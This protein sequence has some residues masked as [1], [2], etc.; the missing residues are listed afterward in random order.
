MRQRAAS[1]QIL[2]LRPQILLLDEPFGALDALTRDQLNVELLRLWQEV[3]QTVVLIT[4][5]IPEAVFLS[6]RVLVMTTDPGR[7]IDDVRDRAAASAR[8]AQHQGSFRSSA[9]TWC[10]WGT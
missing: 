5:S 4:H 6:D 1:G 3:R 10:S 9:T 8:S 2:V 7:V